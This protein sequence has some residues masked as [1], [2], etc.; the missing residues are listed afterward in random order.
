[1]DYYET[2]STILPAAREGRKVLHRRGIVR[3]VITLLLVYSLLRFARAGQAA[4]EMERTAADLGRELVTLEQEHAALERRLLERQS[5]AQMEALAR[6]ELGMVM[7]GEIVFLL[8]EP[9]RTNSEE[10]E[11]DPLWRWK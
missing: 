9:T 6:R 4:A 3:I 7:P 5:P 2:V 11:R 8:P 1:M 10:T